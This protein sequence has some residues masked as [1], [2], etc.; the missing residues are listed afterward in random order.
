MKDLVA[1]ADYFE[2]SMDYMT[3]RTE[4]QKLNK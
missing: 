4:K 1:L 2:V 3:G